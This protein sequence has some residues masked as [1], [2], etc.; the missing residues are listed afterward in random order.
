MTRRVL[1]KN[2]GLVRI[3]SRHDTKEPPTHGPA[4]PG[5]ALHETREA[6]QRR[7]TE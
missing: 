5:S 4:G 6:L 1:E 7:L 2:V 3:R